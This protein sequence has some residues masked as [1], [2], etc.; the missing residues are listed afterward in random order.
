M[1]DVQ[2][3]WNVQQQSDNNVQQQSDNKMWQRRNK[4]RS[5]T[6]VGGAATRLFDDGG[7]GCTFKLMTHLAS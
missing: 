3:N 2:Y 4:E 7:S 6:A 1:N 5:G